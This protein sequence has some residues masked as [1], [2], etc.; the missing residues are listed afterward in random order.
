MTMIDK[1]K[2]SN[3]IEEEPC[4]LHQILIKMMMKRKK[5]KVSMN[6]KEVIKESV[7]AVGVMIKSKMIRIQY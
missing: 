1:R 5:R 6:N 2:L 3:R 4:L 7:K